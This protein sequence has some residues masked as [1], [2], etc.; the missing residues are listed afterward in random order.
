MCGIAGVL[1]WN[2][3][4]VEA[5]RRMVTAL[6]HRGPD[7]SGVIASGAAAL[8]HARL[9]V[10]DLDDRSNQPMCDP[11]GRYWLV[12]NGEIYNFQELRRELESAGI[13]FRTQGDSEVLLQACVAWGEASLARLNGMFAFVFWDSQAE[14]LLLA[15]DRL[16]EKPL[17]YI[18]LPGGGIAFASELQALRLHPQ[19]S[20]AID[21]GALSQFLALNYVLSDRCMVAG[22]RKLHAAHWIRVSRQ[23]IGTPRRYWDLAGCFRNKVNFASEREACEAL[24]ERFDEAVGSRLVSDA[25]L[26]A[27][28]SG[29]L[30][31]SAVVEAMRRLR[32]HQPTV[33]LSMGFI[34]DEFNELP[35]ARRVA[36]LLGVD[37]H[38]CLAHLDLLDSFEKVMAYSDEPFADSSFFPTFHLCR[39][40]RQHVTVALSGDGGDE[41]F[42][43]YETYA[44][45]KIRRLTSPIPAFVSRGI[46]MLL[47]ANWAVN[48][49]KVSTEYKIKKF[50]SG[51]AL[52][53]RRAHYFWRTIFSREEQAVLLRPE[54]ADQVLNVDP[55]ETFLGHFHEVQ[56]CHWLDQALYVDI[57]TWLVDDILHKVDRA[58]M[59][60]ALEVRTPFLDHRLVEFAASLPPELKMPGFCK[61]YLLK[62]AMRDRLPDDII[63]AKKSGFNAPVSHWMVGK[64]A[65]MAK[66]QTLD[67][68][69]TNI[70]RRM[71]I[72]LLW[73]EHEAGTR[74]HGLKLFGILALGLWLGRNSGRYGTGRIQ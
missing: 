38:D 61:K 37:H 20:S 74:D 29:G 12:F 24:S 59:A 39:F 28:L 22:V 23:G 32:P 52:D 50:F 31:S 26:G 69:V 56:D 73:R 71:S 6:H 16:G 2:T 49:G 13:R 67:G 57:K 47:Q 17:F 54:W 55:F 3:P 5:V 68:P 27:F 1:D 10:M 8:G 72:E 34:E 42:A 66:S 43:G 15:R 51:H 36:N 45:D 48:F 21:P 65:D 58:S 62:E 19:T 64:L 35:K 25:P 30:D 7:A 41:L 44:A 11:S 53:T 63:D 4:D 70:F 18:E 40:A 60:H 9:S 46:A 33:T 14:Q